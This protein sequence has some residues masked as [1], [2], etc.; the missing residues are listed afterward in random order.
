MLTMIDIKEILLN[1]NRLRTATR[2]WSDQEIEDAFS[3]MQSLVDSRREMAQRHVDEKIEK[4][5][6]LDSLLAK[7]SKNGLDVSKLGKEAD[8]YRLIRKRKIKYRFTDDN[9][10]VQEW[11][12]SGRMP[13]AFIIELDKGKAIE[14]FLV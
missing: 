13:R 2:E 1:G 11:A 12:G 5:A 10:V 8:V 9:G 6:K 3:R 4:R 7:A 14:S